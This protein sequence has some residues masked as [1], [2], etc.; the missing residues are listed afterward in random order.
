MSPCS[1]PPSCLCSASCQQPERKDGESSNYNAGS[2]LQPYGCWRALRPTLP[3]LI[4]SPF[5]PFN[6]HPTY[7]ISSHPIPVHLIQSPSH[8][9]PISIPS[10]SHPSRARSVAPKGFVVL[11]VKKIPRE[12]ERGRRRKANEQGKRSSIRFVKG[13]I[14]KI[15]HIFY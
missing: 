9:H 6:L 2:W 4:P 12:E 13:T 14:Y 8:L 5:T 11:E 7:P 10:P 15:H 1:Q 3:H